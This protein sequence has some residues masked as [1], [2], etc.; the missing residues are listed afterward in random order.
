M[1]ARQVLK[2]GVQGRS[3]R[4]FYKQLVTNKPAGECIGDC[5]IIQAC[6]FAM[7]AIKK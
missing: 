7:L 2:A 5:V 6:L 1:W 4:T 3:W